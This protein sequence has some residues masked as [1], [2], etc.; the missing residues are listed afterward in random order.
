MYNWNLLNNTIN[1]MA[2]TC[3]KYTCFDFAHCDPLTVINSQI[4][5]FSHLTQLEH[6][7]L[8]NKLARLGNNAV[9]YC[10]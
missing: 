6:F 3:Q 1:F 10:S 9:N 5:Y 4:A 2:D 8:F 7:Q